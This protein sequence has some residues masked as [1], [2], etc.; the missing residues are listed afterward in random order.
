MQLSARARPSHGRSPG[1]DPRLPLH[2][3]WRVC[4]GTTVMH[5][6]HEVQGRS[7]CAPRGRPR[8][9]ASQRFG[10]QPALALEHNRDEISHGSNPSPRRAH[11]SR[12][13]TGRNDWAAPE[14]VT[15][16]FHALPPR[17]P[18]NPVSVWR[19]RQRACFG[20]MRSQVRDLPPRPIPAPR[21]A[22]PR[23]PFDN[24]AAVA[25]SIPVRDTNS[26]MHEQP[27]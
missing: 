9:A 18:I 15:G 24:I 8:R 11:A 14:P 5:A 21:R 16:P 4:F 13:E 25:Q 3:S 19:S 17:G 7:G 22:Q 1:F 2:V 6:P 10:G 27:G 23:D 12:V 26:S 20:S